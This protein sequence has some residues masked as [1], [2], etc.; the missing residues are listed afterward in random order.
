MSRIKKFRTKWYGYG[1]LK[2]GKRPVVPCCTRRRLGNEI[3]IGMVRFK[4]R[5]DGNSGICPR[6]HREYVIE[7]CGTDY[8]FV[9][10]LPAGST[11]QYL[12][13]KCQK[14]HIFTSKVGL[15][16]LELLRNPENVVNM[17]GD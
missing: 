9:S 16:H 7:R 12:C 17:G 15:A 6:C 14:Y 3:D 5:G 13:P 10:V 2:A 1:N 8:R 11:K 4:T